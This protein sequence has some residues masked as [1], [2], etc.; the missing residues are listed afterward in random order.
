MRQRVPVTI[1]SGFLGSGK[2][3]LLNHLLHSDFGLRLAVVV[4]EFGEVGIDADLVA[5]GEQFVEL[6]NGCLCC[7]LNK[8]LEELLRDLRA[9]GGFDHLLVE[10]TGLAEPLPVAWTFERPGLSD[11]FRA[12]AVVTLVD[13]A[14]LERAL[15]EAPECS[16]QIA[17]ADILALNKTDLVGD[18]GDA[19]ERRVREINDRAPLLRTSQARVAWSLILSGDDTP[20]I[21]DFDRSAGTGAHATRFE[22]WSFETEAVFDTTSLEE[23]AYGI[24]REVYRMKG[25]VRTEDPGGWT[26]MHSVAGRFSMSPTTPRETPARSRII[27]IGRGLDRPAL[28]QICEGML[29]SQT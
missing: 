23:L 19:A 28:K 18:K 22:T 5:G 15:A 9:R 2:T 8:Q 4:N 25:L 26:V 12:D 29:R 6:D 21:R 11:Y 16:I 24:P 13:A 27:F 20:R 7:M 17:H 14:N 3:T 10:T 1:I